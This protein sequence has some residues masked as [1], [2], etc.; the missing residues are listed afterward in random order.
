[1][2]RLDSG[3]TTKAPSLPIT[4]AAT[5]HKQSSFS[6]PQSARP[7]NRKNNASLTG[8]PGVSKELT[9]AVGNVGPSTCVCVLDSCSSSVL[10]LAWPPSAPSYPTTS[11]SQGSGEGSRTPTTNPGYHGDHYR[12]QRA[13][14]RSQE[15][16]GIKR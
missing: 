10:P 15:K 11:P 16:N 3:L 7:C 5:S 1:M 13:S 12:Y 6:E 14:N 4:P 2:A 9:R 8:L